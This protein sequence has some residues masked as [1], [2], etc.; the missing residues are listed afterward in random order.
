MLNVLVAVLPPRSSLAVRL[1]TSVPANPS[2]GFPENEP[3][4]GSNFNQAGRGCPP[5]CIALIFS[6]A[7]GPAMKVSLGIWN[8]IGI[9]G[10]AFTSGIGS[11]AA[12]ARALE[13]LAGSDSG[14]MLTEVGGRLAESASI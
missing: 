8:E 1:I 5:A 4:A 6:V 13:L 7:L 14:R 3:V 10:R 12:T 9:P 2:G 11:S